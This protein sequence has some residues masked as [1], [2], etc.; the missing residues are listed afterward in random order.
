[1]YS[2]NARTPDIELMNLDNV[3][4]FRPVKKEAMYLFFDLY[5]EFGNF[6]YSVLKFGSPTS[7]KFRNAIDFP[8][9]YNKSPVG[10]INVKFCIMDFFYTEDGLY[11]RIISA[12]DQ[13]PIL[14][15]SRLE[16]MAIEK[17]E[18]RWRKKYC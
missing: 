2:D 7:F 5:G 11:Y 17:L 13:T 6:G 8:I 18:E 14:F 4:F 1:M 15:L 10:R 9:K 12:E 3:V 16:I